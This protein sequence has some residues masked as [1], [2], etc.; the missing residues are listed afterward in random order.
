MLFKLTHTAISIHQVPDDVMV[1][2]IGHEL[3][4][5]MDYE[6]RSNSGMISFGYN[7]YFSGSYVKKA[8]S[9]ADTYAVN[10]GL[11]SYLV[12]TKK[13]I[14]NHADLPKAYK[15]KIARLYLS[16]DDI[17]EQVRKLEESNLA[18]QKPDL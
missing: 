18:R 4:H 1:G 8:E 14:L 9:I 2:W 10:Q 17:V 11:G 12:T 16:P 6:N 13:F 3:G 7:Y 15:D 5:I